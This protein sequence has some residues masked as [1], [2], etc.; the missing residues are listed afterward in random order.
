MTKR[1][2]AMKGCQ[3]ET[4]R[5]KYFCE[6]HWKSRRKNSKYRDDWNND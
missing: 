4:Y 6:K 3:K 5:D 2:C 1:K